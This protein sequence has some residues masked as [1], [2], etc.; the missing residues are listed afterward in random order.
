MQSHLA[1][2]NLKL[3]LFIHGISHWNA[4]DSLRVLHQCPTKGTITRSYAKFHRTLKSGTHR[5]TAAAPQCRGVSDHI[6]VLHIIGADRL[7]PEQSNYE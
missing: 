1:Y 4:L 5:E 6:D 7:S 3:L 2:K